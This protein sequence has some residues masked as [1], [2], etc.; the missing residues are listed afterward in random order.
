MT[1]LDHTLLRKLADWDV[2]GAPITSVY[3][4]VDGRRYPRR[5]DYEVRLDELLRRARSDA[6]G[7]GRE[8]L[9]SVER[10][11]EMVSAF[12]RETFDR[13][14]TRGLG[15]FSSSRAGLWEVVRVPR[16]VRD[17]VTVAPAVDLLPLEA[18][19][20]TYRPTGTVLVDYEKARLFLTELGRLEEVEDLWDEVP[21]RHEQGGWAQMRM[22]RH[23]DEHRT[24]HLKRVADAAFALWRR[25]GFEHLILAGPAEARGELEGVLHDYLRRRVRARLGLAVTAGPEEILTRVLAVEEELE[26]EAERAAV[27]RLWTAG[28]NDHGVVGLDATLDALAAGR[29]GELVVAFD[30]ARQGAACSACGRLATGGSACPT[31]GAPMGAVPDVVEAAVTLA[32]RSGARVET[33]VED[34]GLGDVGIGAVLRF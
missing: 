11:V 3:L 9:R 6:E 30:L 2:A 28:G 12:V 31:C 15:M 5:S 21:G 33:I 16:P 20:E 25:R 23:V 27:E 22:Q 1:D 26:R 29:V 8:A 4:T 19:L 10:D 34:A 7:L 14:D 18:L 24:K 13:G 17:R 32:L